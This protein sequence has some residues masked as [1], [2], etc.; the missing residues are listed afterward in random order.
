MAGRP[1]SL[2]AVRERFFDDLRDAAEP[3]RVGSEVSSPIIESVENA[4]LRIVIGWE[5]FL[6][7]WVVTCVVREPQVFEAQLQ[8]EVDIWILEKYAM[9]ST[10]LTA[11]GFPP[12]LN[13]TVRLASPS[14]D[15]IRHLI[16]PRG[17]NV[18]LGSNVK[19]EWPK[20][21]GRLLSTGYS[22]RVTSAV[23]LPGRANVGVIEAGVAI[24]NALAHRSGRST[25]EM[26]LRLSTMASGA[27]RVASLSTSVGSYLKHKPAGTHAYVNIPNRTAAALPAGTA[28]AIQRYERR[29]FMI[30]CEEFVRVAGLLSPVADT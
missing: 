22:A 25:A 26:K 21:A 23:P 13:A 11:S 5:V 17:N 28:V 24:R 6:S 9:T 7:E 3:W 27:L 10:Q 29:R 20:T 30:F 8:A 18:R 1:R 4:F 19:K 14:A 15:E 16:D 12:S 2:R